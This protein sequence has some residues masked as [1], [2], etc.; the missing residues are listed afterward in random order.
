MSTDTHDWIREDFAALRADMRKAIRQQTFF[1]I[2]MAFWT[3]VIVL[4][5]TGAFD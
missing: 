4:S 5:I 3:A 1:Y 2:W